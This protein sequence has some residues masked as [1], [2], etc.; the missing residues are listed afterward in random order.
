MALSPAHKFG[1]IIGDILEACVRPILQ[2]IA[3]QFGLYLDYKRPRAARGGKANVQWTDASGNRHNLDFVI[4]KGGTEEVIGRPKAFIE[5]AWRR[6]TKHSR[7]KA[8]EIQGAVLPLAQAYADCHPFLGAIIGGIFTAGSITQLKSLGFE[9]LYF[10]YSSVV[11]AFAEV[12]ID[13]RVDE[14]TS[15]VD[16]QRK[17]RAYEALDETQRLRIHAHLR[18]LHKDDVRKFSIALATVI[19]RSIKSVLIIPLHGSRYESPTIAKAI[20]MLRNYDESEAGTPFVRYEVFVS[21]NNGD[22]IK[23]DFENKTDAISFLRCM[24]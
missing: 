12:G 17:V 24:S 21:Y 22:E 5:S 6:Y 16:V 18:N 8:Q 11:S 2:E 23:G 7:N 15:D 19:K 20:K 1:Q 10:P 13:A 3:D 9:V 14:D 4:E